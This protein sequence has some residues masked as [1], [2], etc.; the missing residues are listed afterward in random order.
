MPSAFQPAPIRRNGEHMTGRSLVILSGLAPLASLALPWNIITDP[1][2]AKEVELLRVGSARELVWGYEY[3]LAYLFLIIWLCPIACAFRGS[4]KVKIDLLAAFM[5]MLLLVLTGS[6]FGTDLG[7]MLCLAGSMV[8]P[9]GMAKLHHPSVPALTALRSSLRPPK[10]V[11]PEDDNGNLMEEDLITREDSSEIEPS[12]PAMA[13][14][15][16][17]D[18]V[19]QSSQQSDAQPISPP[20]HEASPVKLNLS[21]TRT[22]FPSKKTPEQDEVAKP[23]EGNNSDESVTRTDS[24]EEVAPPRQKD[25][26]E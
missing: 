12:H 14:P 7:P 21:I 8:L 4:E 26:P 3:P 11:A 6:V 24:P 13:T 25:H 1:K 15:T 2:L 20:S 19:S 10:P 16:G 17:E 18:A 9:L 5:P 23:V 22:S